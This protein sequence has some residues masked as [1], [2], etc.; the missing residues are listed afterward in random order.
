MVHE[1]CLANVTAGTRAVRNVQLDDAGRLWFSADRRVVGWSPDESAPPIL[2]PAPAVVTALLVADGRVHAGLDDGRVVRWEI[3]DPSQMET[4]RGPAD[5][6]VHS[7]C[8]TAG[9]GIP[10][11]LVA[12]GRPQLDY[13]VL[14]DAYLGTYACD[15][16]LRWGLAAE[17]CILGVNDR[18]DQLFLWQP[19]S[20][21]QPAACVSIGRL[22]G[23]SI[24]D[25]TLLPSP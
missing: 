20:P 22:C 10:R 8:W 12:D 7:L 18:R 13:Q 1:L 9:G 11:L 4:L 17:D 3:A 6:A 25:I 14:G 19:D 21:Q 16:R 15:Q 24:Q 23:R 2:L 5:H